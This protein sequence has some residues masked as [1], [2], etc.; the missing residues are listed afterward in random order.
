MKKIA[1][2]HNYMD[3]IGGA[4]MVVLTLAR[5][6]CADVYAP[7]ADQEHIHKMGFEDM[8]VK[9][10]G[11]GSLPMNAP[12]RQQLA[13]RA[14]RHVDISDKYDFFIIAGDWAISA[15]VNHKP[16]LWYVHSPIREIWD[17]YEYAR[18]NIVPGGLIP[19]LNKYL[20]DVWVHYNR[21]LNKKYVRHAQRLVC[22]SENTKQRV[23]KYLGREAVVIHPPVDTSKFYFE[24][25]GDYWLSVNRLLAHKRVDV[26]MDAFRYIPDEKLIVVGTYEKADHFMEYKK[27]IERMKPPNVTILS[28]VG[29]DELRRLYANCK[30][31]VTTARDEDF[32]L[33]A[34]EAMA[35]GKPVIAPNEGGYRETVLDGVT[36][37]LI[38]DIDSGKLAQAVR[39]LGENP[40]RY[41]EACL[42]RAR[43]FDTD[44][45]IRK[46]KREI[47]L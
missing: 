9:L 26:Q 5:E 41:T 42:A 19:N 10:V 18:E 11:S 33:T 12:A 7:A 16:N 27:H 44:V 4:E 34:V 21:F 45:F 25:T 15:A 20:F 17:L 2:F 36:G 14:L 6:L 38:D 29:A 1:I 23:K 13:L 43:E 28:H 22:N 3:N 37:T 40:G 35:S 39:E 46:I 47:G 31:F 24:K 30:G 8:K 32:G